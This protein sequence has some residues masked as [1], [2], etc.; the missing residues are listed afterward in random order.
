MNTDPSGATANVPAVTFH[1]I[2]MVL[3]I[4]PPVVNTSIAVDPSLT[5]TKPSA[6]CMSPTAICGLSARG[7]AVS[8]GRDGAIT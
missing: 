1:E 2:G 6:T 3:T 5:Y 4:T 7:V 8:S